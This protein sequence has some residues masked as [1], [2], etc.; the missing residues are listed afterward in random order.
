[1]GGPAEARSVASAVCV[2]VGEAPNTKSLLA[3][4]PMESS[5]QGASP[6]GAIATCRQSAAIALD[7]AT[8]VAR[9]WRSHGRASSPFFK[10]P[11]SGDVSI[12]GYCQTYPSHNLNAQSREG[13][14][15]QHNNHTCC[16][17][18]RPPRPRHL[19]APGVLKF[20]RGAGGGA[21]A[22]PFKLRPRT[23]TGGGARAFRHPQ[24]VG[25]SP[26]PTVVGVH[27]LEDCEY[28]A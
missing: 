26:P 4:P 18:P 10:V 6:K 14:A 15:K 7:I 12:S 5:P 27:R 3:A 13:D 25:A 23:S 9:A 16:S 17:H 24:S 1:M 22:P 21:R 19:R 28:T 11:N 20:V 2:G 8:S